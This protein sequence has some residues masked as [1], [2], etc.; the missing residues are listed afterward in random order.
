MSAPPLFPAAPLPPDVAAGAPIFLSTLL[1]STSPIGIDPHGLLSVSSRD[2]FED[3]HLVLH[4]VNTMRYSRLGI[5]H[6]LFYNR[7]CMLSDMKPP[8]VK[9]ESIYVDI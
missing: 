7:R 5:T 9:Q 6:E 1:I 8:V 2:L 4:V 3:S